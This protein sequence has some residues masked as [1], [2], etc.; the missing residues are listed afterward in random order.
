ME[1]EDKGEEEGWGGRE[2]LHKRRICPGRHSRGSS[3]GGEG[4]RG[5]GEGKQ[6]GYSHEPKRKR[7]RLA[8]LVPGESGCRDDDRMPGRRRRHQ[9]GQQMVCVC[10]SLGRALREVRMGRKRRN[11]PFPCPALVGGEGKEERISGPPFFKNPRFAIH[12]SP[13]VCPQNAHRMPKKPTKAL[14]CRLVMRA[15]P[16]SLRESHQKADIAVDATSQHVFATSPQS[17]TL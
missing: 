1:Q 6:V 10:S 16:M 3:K 7:E 2:V 9:A 4:E 12:Q 5:G 11:P 14:R 17:P 8:V 15:R 13:R